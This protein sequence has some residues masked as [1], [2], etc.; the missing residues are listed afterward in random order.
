MDVGRRW[1]AW[2]RRGER[3]RWWRGLGVGVM[4]GRKEEGEVDMGRRWRL[5][6]RPGERERRERGPGGLWWRLGEQERGEWVVEARWRCGVWAPGASVPCGG[7]AGAPSFAGPVLIARVGR[8]RRRRRVLGGLAL[9]RQVLGGWGGPPSSMDPPRR[10]VVAEAAG[11][12]GELTV[13][14]GLGPGGPLRRGRGGRGDTV[15][16]TGGLAGTGGVAPGGR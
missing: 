11:G 6:W 15:P 4:Y 5:W 10:G 8:A 2:R 1:C 12:M 13:P 14:G 16:G 9:C 7:G 3:E